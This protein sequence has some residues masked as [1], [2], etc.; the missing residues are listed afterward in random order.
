[1]QTASNGRTDQANTDIYRIQGSE[2]DWHVAV[3]EQLGM[4]YASK[5]AAFEAAVAAASNAIRDGHE[6]VIMVPGAK[7]GE[8]LLGT[9]DSGGLDWGSLS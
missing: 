2:A 3:N 4:G 8:T 5:E 7:A 9:E 6:V 1:M